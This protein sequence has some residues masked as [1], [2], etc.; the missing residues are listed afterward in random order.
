M[1]IKL[2]FIILIIFFAPLLIAQE[3]NVK[4]NYEG[5]EFTKLKHAWTAQWITHPYES[6]LDYGVF[7]FRK[8]FTL[9]KIYEKFIIYISADNVFK[10][11]VNGEFILRG[12]A[13]GDINNWR[14][15]TID[16]SKYLKIGENVIA[17]EVVNFGEFR[18]GAQQTFQTAFI[19]QSDTEIDLNT[20]K[21]SGWKVA[22]NYAYHFIPFTSDS[23]GGYYVAGPGDKIDF[24]KYP[25]NWN[26]IDFDD[27]DWSNPRSATVEFAV[28]RGFLFGSTWYLVHNELPSMTNDTSYF[29]FV[30]KEKG[31]E[32][33][34][35]LLNKNHVLTLPSYSK[36]SIL[37]DFG[38]HTVGFPQ[39]NF[40]QGAGSSMKITYAEALFNKDSYE[41]TA[42]K[43]W[44][45]G[46][47]NDF[48]IQ[49][50]IRGYYDLLYPDGR[51]HFFTPLA[52][53]TFRFIQLDIETKDSPLI[54]KDLYN[55]NS[56]Y[57]FNELAKFHS[58]ADSLNKIWE[59]AWRTLV[60]SSH[61]V[62]LDPYYEQLQYI[63]DARIESLVS[64]YVSGDD[65]LMRN[66]IKSFD[67]S[68]LP[69]GLTQSRFPSYIVQVIPTYSLLWIGMMHDYM[70]YRDDPD[71]IKQFLPG[72][73]SVLNWFVDRLDKNGKLSS[74]EWWNFTDWTS[75]FQNGIPPGADD[76]V[77]ASVSLQLVKGLQDAADILSYFNDPD[78]KMYFSQSEL[79]QK[80][81]KDNF[82]DRSKKLFAEQKD[83]KQFSQ[84]TNIFA[85]LTNTIP[86]I[87]QKD[88]MNR[89]LV[90]ENLIQTSIYFKFYL[91]RAMQK[92]NMADKYIDM[93]QPW[94]NMINDGMTTFGETDQNPR[95]DCHAWSSSPCFDLLHTVAGIYPTSFGFNDVVIQPEPG[96]LKSFTAELPH[97]KGMIKTNY[98]FDGENVEAEITIP[99]NLNSKFIWKGIE[100]KLKAGNQKFKL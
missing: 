36:A 58:E 93:L 15:E 32:N 78:S 20:N 27:S 40:E 30:I 94:Q 49:K 97:P 31:T 88:L 33:A 4:I 66:A 80:Y 23:L 53:R 68:R 42:H 9:D 89:I 35:D 64:I 55:I 10:L 70:L 24:T 59:V 47:R 5:K 46:I 1:K 73:K 60:N 71:F 34:K 8:K 29:K 67:D 51:S 72:I 65:R 22:K 75:G 19:L 13:R 50:E 14:Y 86:N 61:D 98:I 38:V 48:S 84:H 3:S 77:S 41:R 92:A 21:N 25:I 100:I 45:K 26:H 16:I 85:I 76:D 82:Y 99:E 83:K 56:H 12:P 74:L 6:T 91:F 43:G 2:H 28:G 18:H 62:F 69:E 54:I 96:K 63:G 57:P 52:M 39:L 95:S 17:S 81:I 7:L 79:I 90:D 37:L 11:F 44:E 87:D